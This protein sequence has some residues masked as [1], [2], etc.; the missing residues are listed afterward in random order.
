MIDQEMVDALNLQMNREFFNA[1]L[2]LSM[3]TYFDT[4]NMDGAVRWMELQAQEE[5]GHAMRLYNHLRER[6]ARITVSELDA[7]PSEWDS[8]LAAFE[9][10]YEHECRVTREFDE[11]MALAREKDD[12]ATISFLQWFVDEQV[13]E[14]ASV[15]DIIQKMRMAQDAPGA[16]FMIDRMLGQ[17]GQA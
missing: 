16:R 10:A 17:R 15:D 6:G 2:Y 3:A 12:N 14:E 1:R 11:H 9:A 4:L 8:P 5:N 13:E 7:P